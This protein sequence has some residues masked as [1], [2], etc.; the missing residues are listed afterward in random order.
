[1]IAVDQDSNKKTNKH[2]RWLPWRKTAART[3]TK[4]NGDRR[5]ETKTAARNNKHARWLPWREAAARKHKTQRDCRGEQKEQENKQHKVIA[6]EKHSSKKYKKHKVIAVEKTQQ[7]EHIKRKV[8]AVDKHS[9]KNTK[10]TRWL[11]LRKTASRT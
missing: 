2:A 10:N 11:P 8:I 9:S 3:R 6:V 5:R 7:Q 1:M 4:N